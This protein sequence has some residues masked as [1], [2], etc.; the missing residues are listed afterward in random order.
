MTHRTMIYLAILAILTI[1][2]SSTFAADI[3]SAGVKGT[4]SATATWVGGTVPTA[5]DNV[6]IADGDTV[7]LDGKNIVCTNLTIGEGASGVLL[8]SKTDTVDMVISGNILIKTGGAFK[9]Q[10][11]SLS[12]ATGVAHRLNLGGSLTNDGGTLDFRTGSSGG[13]LAVLNLI[14]SGSKISTLTCPYASSSN[15]EF[16]YITINKTLPGKVV[17][18]S[19]I[20]TAGGSSSGLATANSGMNFQNGIVETGNF[21][22]VYQGTTAA[23]VIGG[24]TTSYVTGNFGRGMS[25]SGGSSKDFLVGDAD[26]YKPLNLRSTTAGSATG[27]LAIVK[28]IRGNANTGTSVLSGA[29]DKV[30]AVRYYQLSYSNAI[31]G[32]ANMSFDRFR[33]TYGIDDGVGVGN[34]DLRIAYSTDNRATWV[35]VPQATPDTTRPPARFNADSVATPITINSGASINIALAR[36]TGTTTNSLVYTTTTVEQVSILPANFSLHQNYPNPFNP[37]TTVRFSLPSTAH[38]T[39]KIFDA[40]GREFTTL[41]NSSLQSGTYSAVWNASGAA[42]G[43]YYYQIQAGDFMMT[44]KMLVIK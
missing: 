8:T 19:D 3:K 18:A 2:V 34:T 38:V 9:V 15:G 24:S 30:S 21:K 25:S 22:L 40:L 14:L 5:T 35:G 7:L 12:G 43:M 39:L 26:G 28:C 33:P 13:N 10:T 31:G 11:I 17:L 37:S 23:Q 44:R 1:A 42:S 6:T 4:W 20:I 32:A 16:N 36:A 29:I 27:H 41:V